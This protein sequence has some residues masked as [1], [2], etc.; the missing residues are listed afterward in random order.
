M[1]LVQDLIFIH[2]NGNKFTPKSLSL[3]MAM[4]QL[5]GS[6]KV[7][8]LLNQ[9]GHC[10]SH[11]FVLCHETAL[12]EINVSNEGAIPATIA[13]LQNVMMAWDNDDFCKDTKSGKETTHVTGGII[14]QRNHADSEEPDVTRKTVSR[15]SSLPQI[16]DEISPYVMGRRVSI[17]LS[18]ALER[19]DLYSPIYKEQQNVGRKLDFSF[20][21]CRSFRDDDAKLPNWTGFNTLLCADK[22]P[23]LS[24]IVYLPIINGPATEYAT[25]NTILERSTQIANKLGVEYVCQVFDEAI[26]SKI[27]QIRWKNTAFLN[28][29]VIRM[30]EFHMAMSFCGA[31]GKLFGDGGLKVISYCICFYCFMK[32]CFLNTQSTFAQP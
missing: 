31:I 26:Y 8:T 24:K 7:I 14:I 20:V 18:D 22:I 11:N 21:A 23:A 16:P 29:F 5:T 6:S 4:R 10:V 19:L 3:A 32:G 15:S 30:D 1:S 28:R 2:S 25:I 27:Q 13:R 17:Q 12:A 9:F